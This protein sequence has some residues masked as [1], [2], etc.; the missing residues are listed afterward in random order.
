MTS[1]AVTGT[2]FLVDRVRETE[3]LARHLR[4]LTISGA[5]MTVRAGIG[6]VRFLVALDAVGGRW[7]VEWTR[8]TRLWD[9]GVALETVDSLDEVCAVLK[10]VVLILLLETE[11]FG[12]AQS[13]AQERAECDD[14]P[15]LAHCFPCHLC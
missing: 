5:P 10:R 2:R 15:R 8:L 3:M 1:H 13:R 6:I 9:P 7:K 4:R 14:G 11:H 12:A